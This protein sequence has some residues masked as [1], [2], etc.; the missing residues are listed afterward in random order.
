MQEYI[1]QEETKPLWQEAV[2]NI[3]DR[4]D[5]VGYGVS[6]THEELKGWMGVDETKEIDGYVNI[7]DQFDYMRGGY[8]DGSGRKPKE[9]PETD[10]KQENCRS[11]LKTK[12]YGSIP[13]EKTD[14]EVAMKYAKMAIADLV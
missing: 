11:D 5:N 4:F 9:Q 7:K 8:R 2:R 6:F 12:S 13:P 3:L 14:H 10:R 1:P